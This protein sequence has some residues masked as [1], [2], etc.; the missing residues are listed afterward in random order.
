MALEVSIRKKLNRFTL[1]VNFETGEG[2]FALLGASGCGKSMTLK[3]IAGIERPDE[4]RIVLDGRVLFDSKKRIDL[5]PQ[6]RRVGYMFQDYALFPNMTV[7]EN[8]MTGM[9][10]KSDPL[11]CLERFRIHELADA[12]PAQLSGGQKQRVAMA[13]LIAQDPDVILLDEP[14]SALDSYLKWQLEQEMHETLSGIGKPV[15]FVSHDRDEVY[16]LSQTVCCID[17]GRSQ[18]PQRMRDFFENP[19]TRTAAILSGCKNVTPAQAV[20]AREL[21]LPEW[22]I[23]I[24][25]RRD[26]PEG[27]AYAGIRAHAFR[28]ERTPECDVQIPVLEPFALEDP[29]EWTISFRAAKAHAMLQWKTAKTGAGQPEIPGELF[30]S[31]DDVML[32]YP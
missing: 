22:G 25:M 31:S 32:L 20:T 27:I 10:P 21:C 18:K 1:D 28:A 16:H 11:P 24:R 12:Y 8:V 17:E 13:R 29:F 14:F 6:K 26:I 4:G 3:C 19:G 5:K 23:R 2:V 9:K 7:K 15:L 30:F